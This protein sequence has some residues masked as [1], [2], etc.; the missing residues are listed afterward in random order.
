M[1][2][3][4]ISTTQNVVIEY[5]LADLRDRILAFLLDLVIIIGVISVTSLFIKAFTPSE[6]YLYFTYFFIL[7]FFLFYS[8]VSEIMTS[9]SS[10]G[11]KALGI[12]VAR[13]D[14][15]EVTLSDYF[16]RWSFRLVDI[17]FSS[18]ALA[19]ILINSSDKGQRLG[20]FL[21]NTTVIRLRPKLNLVLKD[22]MSINSLENYQPVYQNVTEL[23]EKDMI[24]IKSA[25]GQAIKYP[26]EAHKEAINMLVQK[27]MLKLNI[28][29]MP[30]GNTAFLKTLIRDYIV[31]TR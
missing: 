29:E 3:I 5:E 7:P 19:S 18:G 24:F 9:G 4:E 22:I 8:L 2:S 23:S 30:P 15:T 6:T 16:I 1:P 20:D 21:A 31:L 11:K 10:P 17:Y 25:L 14:G 13:T 26:N 27:I 12:K 28:T